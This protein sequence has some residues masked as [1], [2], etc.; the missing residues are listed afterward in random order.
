MVVRTD[1]SDDQDERYC[2]NCYYIHC[3][4]LVE[5]CDIQIPILRYGFIQQS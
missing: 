3:F 5:H 2:D 4:L 1:H